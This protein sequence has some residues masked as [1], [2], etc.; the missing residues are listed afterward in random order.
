[1]HGLPGAA[2]FAWGLRV[3]EAGLALGANGENDFAILQTPVCAATTA[4]YPA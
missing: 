3:D 1:M 4:H 2:Q